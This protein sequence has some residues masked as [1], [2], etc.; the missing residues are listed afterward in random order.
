[1]RTNVLSNHGQHHQGQR[2]RSQQ[3][4]ANDPSHLSQHHN[5]QSQRSG[6]PQPAS[7]GPVSTVSAA[8]ASTSTTSANDPSRLSKH[9]IGQS[10][11]SA[12][13]QPEPEQL[14]PTASSETY[15]EPSLPVRTQ[16]LPA[17]SDENAG[18]DTPSTKFYNFINLV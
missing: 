3:P 10:Q 4:S 15:K 14:E 8:E 12:Q 16:A 2:N 6:Q 1:M 7:P 9:H 11:R 13:P 18:T 17:S 5:G